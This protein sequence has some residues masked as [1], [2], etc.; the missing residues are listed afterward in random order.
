MLV[1]ITK[2]EEKEKEVEIRIAQEK[3]VEIRIAPDA[4]EDGL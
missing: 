4:T 2:L 3:E 1:E